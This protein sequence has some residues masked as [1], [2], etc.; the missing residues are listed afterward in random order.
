MAVRPHTLDIVVADMARALAFYRTLGLDAPADADNEQQTQIDTMGGT[1]L[2]FITETL[3]RQADPHWVTPIGQ[4]VT[5]AC[6]CDGPDEVDAV[7]A[8]ATGA[9]YTGLK[10]PW[11]AFWGQHYAMLSDPDG[12]RVDLFAPIAPAGEEKA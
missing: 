2:G 9:G 11:D 3:M 6:Q 5:L 12:N 8:R 1:T 4:R 10:A 7:Y